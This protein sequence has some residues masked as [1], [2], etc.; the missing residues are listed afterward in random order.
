[1]E[2]AI[3]GRRDHVIFDTKHYLSDPKFVQCALNYEDNAIVL[4]VPLKELSE[5]ERVR[6]ERIMNKEA[7]EVEVGKNDSFQEPY[8]FGDVDKV[9]DKVEDLFRLVFLLPIDYDISVEY[10]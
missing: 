1:M 4:D 8:A 9:T 5:P 6:A 2:K 7:T 10:I 3:E